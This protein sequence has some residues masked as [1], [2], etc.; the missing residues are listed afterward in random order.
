MRIAFVISSGVGQIPG[1]TDG[2]GDLADALRQL[3]G[4]TV[5]LNRIIDDR[6]RMRTAVCE[7]ADAL[8][9]GNF[10]RLYGVAHSRGAEFVCDVAWRPLNLTFN[11]FTFS[12]GWAP[13]G[14][15]MVP[16]NVLSVESWTQ[17]T[18]RPWYKRIPHGK[19]IMVTSPGTSLIQHE[20][21]PEYGHNRLDSLPAFVEAVMKLA[22][23]AAA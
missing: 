13:D 2:I 22:N 5:F 15:L 4:V 12:D 6:F 17:S 21:P 14:V 20:A 19:L 18:K 16:R 3:P 23:P 11:K 1:V 7:M 9:A 8:A 10:D